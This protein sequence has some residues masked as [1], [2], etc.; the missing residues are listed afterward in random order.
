MAA[1]AGAQT[2]PTWR[3]EARIQ[4]ENIAFRLFALAAIDTDPYRH[5]GEGLCD[6][7]A[8]FNS[9]RT[10][11]NAPDMSPLMMAT[12]VPPPREW[13]LMYGTVS[14]VL[15]AEGIL[16]KK[17]SDALLEGEF[18][19]IRLKNWPRQNTTVDGRPLA[20]CAFRDGRYSYPNASGA[21]STVES[22]DY[23]TK[24]TPAEV[25]ELEKKHSDYAAK[26]RS[27]R[28]TQIAMM[29]EEK[30][31][32]EQEAKI[33]TFQFYSEKAKT[34]DGYAQFRLAEIYL[35]GLGIEPDQEQGRTWLNAAM[36]NG[37]PEATNLWQTL[38]A[39]ASK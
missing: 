30:K 8:F 24:A 22:Y 5:D 29:A 32:K 4:K 17:Y 21:I 9:T 16:V 28:E 18:Q 38:S 31:R 3:A 23:G 36:A 39:S 7:T 13:T 19:I 2:D 6:L 37:R 27:E 10:Y 15:G 34:G 26:V 14:R 11:I 25:D 33:K 35:K 20:F 1:S 12:M